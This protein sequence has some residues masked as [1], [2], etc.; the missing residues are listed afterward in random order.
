MTI[1]HTGWGSS[2]LPAAGEVVEVAVAAASA[3]EAAKL[4]CKIVYE[5]F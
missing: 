3:K 1:S 2:S 5:I 4:P